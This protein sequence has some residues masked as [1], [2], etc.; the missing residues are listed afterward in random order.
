MQALAVVIFFFGIV[1]SFF[2]FYSRHKTD[3]LAL[4]GA[5]SAQ[6]VAFISN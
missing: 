4:D 5:F 3:N 1:A 6:I 2:T